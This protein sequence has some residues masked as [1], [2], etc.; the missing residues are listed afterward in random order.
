MFCFPLYHPF[1]DD[2]DMRYF[3][4]FVSIFCFFMM[5][6]GSARS[7][8]S[9]VWAFGAHAGI[10]FNIIPPQAIT[11]RILTSEGS[12]VMCDSMGQLLM[13]TDGTTVWDRNHIVMPNGLDLPEVGL[14]ITGSTSQGTIIIPKPGSHTQ[15]YVFS[16]GKFEATAQGY[17]GKMYYSL[18]D[19]ELNSGLG[20]VVAG[21]K[22]ILMDSLLS[23]HMTAV[24]GND[25]NIWLMVYSRTAN[26]FKSYNIEV[27]GINFNPVLSPGVPLPSPALGIGTMDM[28]ND[29]TKMAVAL[30]KLYLYHFDADLGIVND[31]VVLDTNTRYY[32]VSFSPDNSKLYAGIDYPNTVNQFNLISGDS[33]QM[34]LSKTLI[35]SGQG[36][37]GAIKRAPDG[38]VYYCIRTFDTG[39]AL[40]VIKFPNLAG[41][42]CQNIA[43]GFPLATGT[44]S[45][46]GLPNLTMIATLKHYYN[47]RTDTAF[48]VNSYLMEANNLNGINYLWEN[49]STGPTRLVNSPGT[50]WVKYKIN[51]PCIFDEYTDTIKII[52]DFTIQNTWTSSKH[53]GMCKADSFMMVA[54][55]LN[56]TG[57]IWEDG[58]TGTQRLVN[59]TGTYWVSYN[60]DSLCKHFAD[61]FTLIYPV[62]DYQVSFT[63]DSILCTG[64]TVLFQNTSDNHFTDFLWIFSPQFSSTVASPE[65]TYHQPGAYQTMLTGTINGICPDTAM[66]AV[67]VDSVF[68]VTFSTDREHI[69]T[70]ESVTFS[71]QTN[72]TVTDVLLELGDQTA[73]TL[74][75]EF[76]LSHAYDLAGIKPIQVTSNFRACA[77]NSFRDTIYVHALPQVY[78]G[79]DTGLC[80]H[81]TAIL[82]KN[83]KEQPSGT[84]RQIWN[85]GDTTAVLKALHPGTYA[86]T[87][88]SIPSGCSTTEQIEVH[89]DCYID[90]PNVFSPNNDGVNDYFFPRQLLSQKVSAFSMKIFN[91]WGQVVFETKNIH[92]RGWD[93]TLNNKSQPEGVYIYLIDA[94]INGVSSEKYQGNVTLM[95]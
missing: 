81:G 48:C 66:G 60:I 29:R 30:D 78:L 7:Q 15:Y 33:L 42:A 4:P 26:V 5:L 94:E 79:P 36:F 74:Y 22:G 70:G 63:A 85:T 83:I 75:N 25:C 95:H 64:D 34:I 86:L 16:L 52:F 1:F 43:N 40:N 69:C 77:S 49:G 92:G 18:V 8:Y 35:S 41:T 38:K 19:M 21:V 68:Q 12:A 27:S 61:T 89:K 59:Q 71:M 9:N 58:S 53:T 2:T 57:Y 46:F 39:V 72:A 67:F 31:P 62:T 56:G 54:S 14:N 88:I 45:L 90:I 20:N 28:S 6:S 93:G 24:S 82:L 50:Y 73:L 32:G 80:L 17:F 87:V 13:Y 44:G 65:Y 91:R 47:S 55:N 3:Y 76:S 10:N 84:Y 37:S 23:E 51:S 11:T